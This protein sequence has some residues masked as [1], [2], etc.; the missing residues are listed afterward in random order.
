MNLKD[1][2]L[3]QIISTEVVCP[4]D[5][6]PMHMLKGGRLLQWMDNTAAICAQ[7]Y[8]G[9]ICVTVGIQDVRFIRPS[10]VG[11]M[12]T[13]RAVV[14]EIFNTSL[15]IAVEASARKVGEEESR[16]IT[17]GSFSFVSIG[18]DGKPVPLK[19]AHG[20]AA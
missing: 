20:K 3:S 15:T 11:D 6:N 10:R 13:V 12:I 18:A 16:L 14:S 5:T 9:T 4:D 19:K 1:P 8:A 17:T 2:G 7:T